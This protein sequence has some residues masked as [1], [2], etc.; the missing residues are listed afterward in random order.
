MPIRPTNKNETGYESSPFFVF[1][2]SIISK[3]MH[4]LNK[5][6]MPVKFFGADRENGIK[7]ELYEK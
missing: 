5:K 4:K 6:T 3:I 2:R 1:N 7:F